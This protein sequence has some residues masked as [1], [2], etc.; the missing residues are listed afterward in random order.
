V[1]LQSRD[2]PLAFSLATIWEVAFKTSVGRPGFV[3]DPRS[4]REGSIAQGFAE[5]PIRAE[6]IVRVGALPWIHRDPFD[7][8]LVA[9]CLEDKLTLLTVDRVLRGYVRFVRLV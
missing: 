2:Q 7:R 6:H 3:L 5:L 1:L 8:M 4:L 9:Q